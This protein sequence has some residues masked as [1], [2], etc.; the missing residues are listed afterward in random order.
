[1]RWRLGRKT[2][3]RLRRTAV[4]LL[5]VGN[6]V[7][8]A[9]GLPLPLPAARSPLSASEFFPCMNCSCGCRTAEQCW[10]HC[11]CYSM[12]QKL[13]WAKAHG[14]EPPAFVREAAEKEAQL[15]AA[16]SPQEPKKCCPCCKKAAATPQQA[17][18]Q[19]KL[20]FVKAL[21]CQGH[22]A[23]GLLAGLPALLPKPAAFTPKA[24][25]LL[26]TI[27]FATPLLS[28]VLVLVPEPPPRT[29]A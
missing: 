29:L 11:C 4:A 16:S 9:L 5:L 23:A 24:P 10:R 27:S 15:A 12:T 18:P 28:E 20:V 14:V 2:K 26:E 21:E 1:M 3:A 22:G 6:H 7:V 13:A 19:G 8:L 25:P 17:A